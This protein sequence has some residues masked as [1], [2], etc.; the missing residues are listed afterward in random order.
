MGRIRRGPSP[1]R[2]VNRGEEDRAHGQGEPVSFY[3]SPG[4]VGQLV[5][6]FP[7]AGPRSRVAWKA[8]SRA[9]TS[10]STCL[11]VVAG[12]NHTPVA[13]VSALLIALYPSAFL[14]RRYL[15]RLIRVCQIF[16]L[17]PFL[18]VHG[19]RV[20]GLEVAVGRDLRVRGQHVGLALGQLRCGA[21]WVD[22]ADQG[23]CD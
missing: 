22:R 7:S 2:H 6:S 20:G 10:S 17:R 18:D 3:G 9:F 12:L 16:V 11:T 4:R 15:S 13:W 1:G 5:R 8:R 23:A 14:P 21:G 19:R